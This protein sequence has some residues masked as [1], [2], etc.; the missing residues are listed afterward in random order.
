MIRVLFADDDI[1]ALS[2][3]RGI[4]NWEQEG[5]TVIGQA[6]TG[7][8]C[9][10]ILKKQQVDL[11]FLDIDMPEKNGLDVCLALQELGQSPKV[12][13]LSNYDNFTFVR[14]SMR[15]G[16]SDYLLKHQITPEVIT[17]K[18]REI[19][20]SLESEKQQHSQLSFLTAAAKQQY[21]KYLLQNTEGGPQ[22]SSYLRALKEFNSREN[23]LVLL[24]ITNFEILIHFVIHMQ[25]EKFISSV[26][27]TAANIL[28]SAGN[29]LV[30]PVGHGQFAVLFNYEDEVS[31]LEIQ[32]KT[33]LTIHLVISNLQRLYSVSCTWK[34]SQQFSDIFQLH[35]QYSLLACR[36][37][38][39]AFFPQKDLPLQTE[40]EFMTAL[41]MLDIAKTDQILAQIYGQFSAPSGSLPQKIIFQLIEIAVRFQEDQK[42]TP[43]S[44]TDSDII[45]QARCPMQKDGVLHFL[46]G[47]FKEILSRCSNGQK[48]AYSSY[49]KKALLYIRTNY[50]MDISLSTAAEALNVSSAHLA[51]KFKTET[52]DS[53]VSRLIAYRIEIAQQLMRTTDLSLSQIAQQTG[54]NGYNYFLRCYKQR[55]GKTAAAD[56]AVLQ[57]KAR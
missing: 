45:K 54:F 38:E 2:R 1:L 7:R 46:Q 51:R 23:I 6:M 44:S 50:P 14:D 43:L 15:F 26:T 31:K 25:R 3:L 27:A 21:L 8:D 52:G 10:Q 29:G 11:L 35:D 48:G 53:F 41:S 49:V 12:V 42:L 57:E 9:L 5:F 36:M 55:T 28:Q 20:S 13:I 32:H 22:D 37:P 47:Y 33:A 17:E 18:L 24:Q 16:A 56:M 4:V 34:S 30:T 39:P 19:R 40:K